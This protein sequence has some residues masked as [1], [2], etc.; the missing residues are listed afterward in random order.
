MPQSHRRTVAR[1]LRLDASSL[2][3]SGVAFLLAYSVAYLISLI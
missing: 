3:Q 2:A 1:A